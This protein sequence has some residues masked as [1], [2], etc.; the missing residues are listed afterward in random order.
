MT[1]IV[2][3]PPK[4]DECFSADGLHRLRLRRWWVE[5]PRRWV[6]WLMLNPSNAGKKDAAGETI[7]D[8]TVDCVVSFSRSWGYDGCVVVNLYSYQDGDTD[9]MKSWRKCLKEKHGRYWYDKC[10]EMRNNLTQIEEAGR[11][12]C[13]RVA[14][15]GATKM[16]RH[17]V[18]KCIERFEQPFDVRHHGW[19]FS[20][21]CV[22]L[23]VLEK[24]KNFPAHPRPQRVSERFPE[25][26]KH[27]P[28]RPRPWD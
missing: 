21:D 11:Y 19:G 9:K 5:Q 4:G 26:A 28:W 6:A 20:K 24:S 13:L 16:D 8:P 12:S 1:H 10:E 17:W 2:F 27:V 23:R 14:A 15:F 22:C 7:S 25:D 18:R 3:N